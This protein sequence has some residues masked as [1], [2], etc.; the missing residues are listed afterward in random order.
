[1]L[2]I[3]DGALGATGGGEALVALL[4]RDGGPVDLLLRGDAVRCL[5]DAGAEP[6]E[7]AVAALYYVAEEAAA[8]GLGRERLRAGEP[9]AQESL[10]QLLG[11]YDQIWHF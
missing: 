10:P 9:I 2:Q 5:A 1:V 7:A 3:L 8:R 11:R 6:L 4:R